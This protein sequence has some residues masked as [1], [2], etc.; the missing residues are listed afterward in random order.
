MY[1]C[2]EPRVEPYD[3]DQKGRKEKWMDGRKG[4]M[5]VGEGWMDVRMDGRTLRMGGY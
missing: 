5:D 2:I 4:L 1:S 3:P